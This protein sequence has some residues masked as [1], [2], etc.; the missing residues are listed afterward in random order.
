MRRRAL[1]YRPGL[2]PPGDADQKAAVFIVLAEPG[3]STESRAVALF[4]EA[5]IWP[6]L[7]QAQAESQNTAQAQHCGALLNRVCQVRAP[8]P[9]VDQGQ[10]SSRKAGHILKPP[11]VA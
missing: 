5:V 10:P 1:S 4:T 9:L 8:T 7:S 3:R 6:F 2:N 11:P